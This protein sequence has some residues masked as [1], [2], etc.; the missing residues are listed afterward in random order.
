[1]T[2]K[3]LKAYVKYFQILID[4]EQS[5]NRKGKQNQGI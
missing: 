5:Q 2:G 3:E 1:M 4:I